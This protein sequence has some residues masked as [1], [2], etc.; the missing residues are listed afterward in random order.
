[1]SEFE[2]SYER[3]TPE[4]NPEQFYTNAIVKAMVANH[5]TEPMGLATRSDGED[6]DEPL[7]VA[8]FEVKAEE[9]SQLIPQLDEVDRMIAELYRDSVPGHVLV[10][11]MGPRLDAVH[12]FGSLAEMFDAF[13]KAEAYLGEES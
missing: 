13:H 9:V 11:G 6:D 10:T 4:T 1:M 5:I 2:P 7:W 12:R 8:A 3:P